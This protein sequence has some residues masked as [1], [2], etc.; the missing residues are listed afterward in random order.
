M[1]V[2]KRVV[3]FTFGVQRLAIDHQLLQQPDLAGLARARGQLLVVAGGRQHGL[4]QS[5]HTVTL[6]GQAQPQSAHLRFAVP[7]CRHAFDLGLG[8]LC[9]RLADGRGVALE[10][11][12]RHGERE[13]RHPLSAARRAFAADIEPHGHI[14]RA[15]GVLDRQPGAGCSLARGQ[16]GQPWLGLNGRQ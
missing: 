1:I 12:Q 8:R 14:R 11:G 2:A 16:R 6:A 4:L 10:H 5:L 15:A 7:D 3:E 13:R 9:L